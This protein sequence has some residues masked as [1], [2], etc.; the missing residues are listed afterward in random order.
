MKMKMFLA[1]VLGLMFVSNVSANLLVNGDFEAGNITSYWKPVTMD[2]PSWYRFTWGGDATNAWL[3][4][5]GGNNDFASPAGE[6]TVDDMA[7][8][9]R[10]A[11]TGIGQVIDGIVEGETFTL[12]VDCFNPSSAPTTIGVQIKAVWHNDAGDWL[13][14]PAGG[15]VYN[16]A[17]FDP[18]TEAQDTWV[19]VS[20]SMEA[21]ATA[22]GLRFMLYSTANGGSSN[23]VY[24]DNASVVPEPATLALLG[25]GSL[26]LSRRKK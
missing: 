16:I 13:P 20:G 5:G 12:S 15:N 26:V 17:H 7:M 6:I 25:L 1:V 19:T 14:N 22:T 11:N 3:T 9:W 18:T 23:Y 24:A 8:K 10:W 2:N 4:D 21:P